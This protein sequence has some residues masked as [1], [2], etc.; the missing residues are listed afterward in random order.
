MQLHTAAAQPTVAQAR[1]VDSRGHAAVRTPGRTDAGGRRRRKRVGHQCELAHAHRPNSG[2]VLAAVALGIFPVSLAGSPD[3]TTVYVLGGKAGDNF[4]LADVDAATGMSLG[5]VEGPQATDG[6]LAV[7]P[8]GVWIPETDL[9]RQSTRM[10]LF[11][12]PDLRPSASVDDLVNDAVPYV[13][14]NT[15]WVIDSGGVGATLCADA[16]TGAVRANGARVGISIGTMLSDTSATYL[17][18]DVGVNDT[19][20]RIATTNSCG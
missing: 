20:L 18:N 3:G 7:T 4:V 15:L 11:T 12:G 6:P 5:R 16:A 13:A 2:R 19:L 10:Q 17:L 14:G 1:P 9:T 8:T